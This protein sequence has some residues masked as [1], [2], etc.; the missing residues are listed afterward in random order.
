MRRKTSTK[1]RYRVFTCFDSEI[2]IVSAASTHTR[3]Q[4]RSQW[5]SPTLYRIAL[6][7]GYSVAVHTHTPP[8]YIIHAHKLWPSYIAHPTLSVRPILFD[9]YYYNGT[10]VAPN[11]IKI[12]FWFWHLDF[13]FQCSDTEW[14]IQMEVRGPMPVPSMVQL[15][16]HGTTCNVMGTWWV[17]QGHNNGH[18]MIDCRSIVWMRHTD[19]SKRA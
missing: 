9:H 10:C 2:N 11:A 5:T 15:R 12:A 13:T 7:Y 19:G 1:W 3:A 17:V 8:N 6:N 4:G 14:T 16:R 18:G